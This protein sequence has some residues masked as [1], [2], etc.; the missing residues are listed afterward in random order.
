M[1]QTV[2]GTGG[3][4]VRPETVVILRPRCHW[5][6]LR[7]APDYIVLGAASDPP[8]LAEPGGNSGRRRA[9]GLAEGKVQRTPDRP[10]GFAAVPFPLPRS[11]P[12]PPIL[13]YEASHL[14]CGWEELRYHW[15]GRR[16]CKIYDGR[17]PDR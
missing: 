13:Y 6:S 1:E 9:A 17:G 12:S 14:G 15:T 7:L 5:Y 3:P 16:F 2:F 8:Q 11:E 10:P 4:G